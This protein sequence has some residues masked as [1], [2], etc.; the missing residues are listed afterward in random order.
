MIDAVWIVRPGDR[1]DEL[2]YSLRSAEAN[3]A[4]TRSVTVSGHKPA[5]LNCHHLWTAQR[6]EPHVNALTNLKAALGCST[7]TERVAIFND[8][9]YVTSRLERLPSL[10]RGPLAAAIT[11]RPNPGLRTTA[12][13]ETA[14]LLRRLGIRD[15]LCYDLHTPAVFHRAEL[16]ETL[17]VIAAYT[18]GWDPDRAARILWKTVHGNLHPTHHTQ[19]GADVKIRHLETTTWPAPLLSTTDLTFTYGAVGHHIRNLLPHPSR[20]EATQ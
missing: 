13:Q 2:R 12:L 9:F 18:H 11:E 17:D 3:L 20:Y 6:D 19:P 5:W 7:L 14:T 8:D 4:N 16:A 1:N 10:H 15:P